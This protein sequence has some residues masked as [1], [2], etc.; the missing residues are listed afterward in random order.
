MAFSVTWYSNDGK[1][2]LTILKA[3]KVLF[4]RQGM[5]CLAIVTNSDDT[6]TILKGG[7]VLCTEDSKEGG[8]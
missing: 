8:E 1:G 3:K 5:E 4:D 6:E 7:L 2:I